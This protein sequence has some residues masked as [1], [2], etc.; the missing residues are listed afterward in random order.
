[1]SHRARAEERRSAVVVGCALGADAR[2]LAKVGYA[3]TGF[4]I[5]PTAIELASGR[6]V[7]GMVRYFVADV[8]EPPK[9]WSRAFDLVV[10]II[11]VQALPRENHDQAIRNISGLVAPGGRLLVIAA[12]DEG[13]P[14]KPDDPLPLTQ[15]E[16]NSFARDGVVAS[17]IQ[18]VALP[19]Q[20][21]ERRWQAEFN[22]PR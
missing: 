13:Q 6:D 15:A 17:R 9:T 10:E 2:F 4:D 18:Q 21:N 8:L 5:A 14:T 11:T 19:E 1:M 12:I 20:P 7:D 22:R 3:T 16:I